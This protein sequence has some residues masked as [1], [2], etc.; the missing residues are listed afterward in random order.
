M[1]GCGVSEWEKEFCNFVSS[2]NKGSRGSI[3]LCQDNQQDIDIKI[4]GCKRCYKVRNLRDLKPSIS[5][6][7]LRLHLANAVIWTAGRP[8]RGGGH[9]H[10]HI[11]IH[12]Q[13]NI[14]IK[15]S[16]I[17]LEEH[18]SLVTLTGDDFSSRNAKL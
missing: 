16:S 7:F 4:E 3:T 9:A 6:V 18:H 2:L 5:N 8:V 15:G 12:I 10:T 11:Y 13:T 1:F 14:A 17:F